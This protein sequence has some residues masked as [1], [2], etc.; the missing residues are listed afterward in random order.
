VTSAPPAT[1]APGLGL[2]RP[3][4]HLD[5]AHP[6]HVRA[7]IGAPPDHTCTGTG[8]TPPTSAQE[9]GAGPTTPMKP[10]ACRSPDRP[11]EPPAA[12]GFRPGGLSHSTA[13]ASRGR[14]LACSAGGRAAGRALRMSVR[15]DGSG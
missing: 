14:A 7:G 8:R 3:H 13:A 2:P 11:H 1:S 15:H 4:L 5:W 6:C 10:G 12:I 9:R